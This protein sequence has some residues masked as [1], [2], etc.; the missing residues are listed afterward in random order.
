V[1]I[2]ATLYLLIASLSMLSAC[3]GER[4]AKPATAAETPPEVEVYTVSAGSSSASEA[5][6]VPSSL[7]VEHE[8]DLLAEEQGRLIEVQADEGRRVKRGQVLAQLDD[9]DVRQQYEQARA[10]MQSLETQARESVVLR[11][12]A[13]VELGRQ[14][15]LRKEGLGSQRDHDRARFNVEAMRHEVE[16]ANFDLQRAKAKVEG[17]RLHLA[18]MQIKAPFDGIVSRRYARV[19]ETLM[20]DQKVL[21]LT[22]LRPL[23]VRFTVP[24]SL[25][26]AA[27]TGAVVEVFTGDAST[28][29][30]RAR[31]IRTGYVVDPASGSVECI[32]RLLDPVPPSL[33]PGMSAEVKVAGKAP[34][35]ATVWIPRSA[36]HTLADGNIEIFAVKSDRLQKRAVKL[37]RETTASVQVL[38]GVSAGD[39]IVA[40]ISENL[41]DGMAVRIRP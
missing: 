23:L 16:K 24:E 14:S 37:G 36:V 38:G 6:T 20:R 39:R 18:R 10:A 27:A 30:V 4:S 34:A 28:S 13:E 9:S 29:G 15:D 31:V 11:Q 25:R 5:Y 32:A 3:S 33:V 8:A 41:R 19:G 1:K 22:E 26:G 35:S 21:R 12:S 2:R 7:M 17:D 40:Q